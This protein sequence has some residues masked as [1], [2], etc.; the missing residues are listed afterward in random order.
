MFYYRDVCGKVLVA[1]NPNCVH[2][3]EWSDSDMDLDQLKFIN[4]YKKEALNLKRKHEQRCLLCG[5]ITSSFANSHSIPK[6]SL[7][8]I[9]DNGT[10]LGRN[11]MVSMGN[12]ITDF[13]HDNVKYYK[14]GTNNSGVFN[15]ICSKCENE[16]FITIEHEEDFTKT[17]WN[18]VQLTSNSIKTLLYEHNIKT[19]QKYL[20]IA[21]RNEFSPATLNYKML[22]KPIEHY[23]NE[24]N[25]ISRDITEYE[26]L[27][28]SS[29]ENTFTSLVDE[30]LPKKINFA[31][32]AILFPTYDGY[33]DK[34]SHNNNHGLFFHIIP[35]TDITRVV[36]Y[37]QSKS[38]AYEK[39]KK[40]ISV[41]S[42]LE[43]KLT[44]LSRIIFL[45]SDRYYFNQQ[46]IK[47]NQ[48]I[49]SDRKIMDVDFTQQLVSKDIL[50]NA[51]NKLKFLKMF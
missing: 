9:A 16:K 23:D 48:S 39:I 50:D 45:H 5:N 41:M 8:S 46:F 6:F 11:A 25:K 37:Y 17:P 34:V 7:K 26:K 31:M 29:D 24:I 44:Y 51:M 47:D 2:L 33:Y 35:K 36:I 32:T 18:N 15:N 13:I 4:M 3:Q 49:L 1:S 21:R 12:I 28:I 22:Q 14:S 10:V 30:L 38:V 20:F 43:E 40:D 27:L 19:F 42:S